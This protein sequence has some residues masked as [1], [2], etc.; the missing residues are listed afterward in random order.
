LPAE[1]VR[2]VDQLAQSEYRTRSN[3]IGW[4]VREGLRVRS[5][6]PVDATKEGE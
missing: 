1:L 6:A 4:F 5:A 3:Q 2:E